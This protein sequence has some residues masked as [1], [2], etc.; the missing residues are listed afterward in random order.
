M[1][2]VKNNQI[3]LHWTVEQ[4]LEEA[5]RILNRRKTGYKTLDA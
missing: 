5:T 2:I 3:H 1:N 4:T